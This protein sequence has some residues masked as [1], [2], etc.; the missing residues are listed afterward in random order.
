MGT[1][2]EVRLLTRNVQ[3]NHAT[4]VERVTPFNPLFQGLQLP[5]VG[6]LDQPQ[7]LAPLNAEIN[8]QAAMIA[9][10][11]DF[12]FLMLLTIAAMPLILLPGKPPRREQA[13]PAAPVVE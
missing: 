11:D 10:I 4:P 1:S 3:I 2:L 9:D 8:R 5:G 6:E 12:K 13:G 7:A